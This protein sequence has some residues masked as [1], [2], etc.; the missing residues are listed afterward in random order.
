MLRKFGPANGRL[1]RHDSYMFQVSNC[2]KTWPLDGILGNA[3][4]ID[5]MNV[6]VTNHVKP[7]E[8]V[9]VLDSAC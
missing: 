6:G 4:M 8:C 7:I 5:P 3:I 9:Q 1:G 2:Q